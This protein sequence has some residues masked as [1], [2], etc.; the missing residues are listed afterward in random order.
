M[1]RVDLR[2]RTVASPETGADVIAAIGIGMGGLLAARAAIEG[3][4][5]DE[6]VL[7]GAPTR[8][9]AL[10]RELRAFSRMEVANVGEAPADAPSAPDGLIANGYLLSRQ[11][12][13]DLEALDLQELAGTG[14]IRRALLL[15][16]D[17]LRVDEHL[18]PAMAGAGA[19][20]TV[21]DGHGYGAMTV[22]P[23]EARPPTEVF[24]AVERWLG[25]GD[26]AVRPGFERVSRDATAAEI[27]QLTHDGTEISERPLFFERPAGRLFGILT[28]PAGPRRALCAVLL[29]AGP[30]RRMG[31]NRMW[32]Q[33]ARRWAA[34][35]VPALRVDMAAI[36]DSDGDSAEP[37]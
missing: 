31:P 36:G 33:T 18:E 15:S 16:R 8:G 17:G 23:Q 10:V 11:T 5:I 30:Q 27:L 7:W 19:S 1:D 4:P 13:A 14:A 26:P 3:A 28:E 35:G 29:N 22:E 25:E 9:R 24:E 21:A 37:G 32:V 12:I 34:R 20:V 6:L 2:R